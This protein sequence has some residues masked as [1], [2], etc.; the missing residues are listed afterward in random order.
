MNHLTAKSTE[1]S[2]L[3]QGGPS[4][5]LQLGPDAPL[6]AASSAAF[7]HSDQRLLEEFRALLQLAHDLL[8]NQAPTLLSAL[9]AFHVA[10]VPNRWVVFEARRLL[11]FLVKPLSAK[12]RA[13]LALL[14]LCD[15]ESML[16]RQEDK[17]ALCGLAAQV[18]RGSQRKKAPAPEIPLWEGPSQ[19]SVQTSL[20]SCESKR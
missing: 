4:R 14:C 12:S 8:V 3:S 2:R 17:F 6:F 13:H 7:S 5:P 10:R 16:A 18:D 11:H 20:M 1:G 19:S 9:E 15:L